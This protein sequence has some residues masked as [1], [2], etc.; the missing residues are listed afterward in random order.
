MKYVVYVLFFLFLS[1]CT[2]YNDVDKTPSIKGDIEDND[3]WYDDMTDEVLFMRVNIP[4]PNDFNCT[5]F[6]DT[7]G[8]LRPCTLADVN[9]DTDANDD[10]EPLLHV[11]MQTDDFLSSPDFMN[12]SFE[13]K[14]KSTR[15]AP[16]KSYRIKLDENISLYRKERTFQ[17]NKHPYD[18]SRVR[19]KLAFDFFREIPHITSL[20]TE[21]VYL[22][23]N[24]SE[25]NS[26]NYGLFTHIEK[27][28][29][30]FLINRG[31]NED[32]NL[33]KAQNF[34]FFLH[35]ELAIDSK[36]KPK[37][38]DLFDTRLEIERGKN[39]TVLDNMLHEVND[40]SNNFDDV[41][42]KYFNRNN[43]ITWMAIN[44]V[45]AN[46]DTVSQNFFLLNPINSDTFYFL[47]WDYDGMG[48]ATEKYAKWELGISTWWE[49]PVHKRFLSIEQNR[50]ELDA[51]VNTLRSVYITPENIQNKLNIYE[52]L[53]S[54]YIARDPDADQLSYD[55]W[56][57]ELNILIPRIDENIANYQS[58]FGHP[59]PFWQEA[60]YE[61]G[62]LTLGWD[63]SVDLEGDIIEYEL[64]VSAS[65]DMNNSF[66]DEIVEEKSALV[67]E[68][69]VYKTEIDLEP[70]KYY[71]R[72][73]SREV[74]N[75]EH[76]QIGF[77]ASVQI[78][79]VYY[80]GVLEF[81]VK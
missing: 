73:I 81:E 4:V 76:Y 72:V 63:R 33:Y 38:P 37:D 10:Y 77:E 16:Q 9:N 20:K 7:N 42:E 39:H 13:Q 12:A 32:D 68:N 19:N 31:W 26:S 18:D 48:R 41:F 49:I 34:A 67:L 65:P 60:L 22:D 56:Q 66:I 50:L 45:L 54:K 15:R 36:G 3:S 11:N 47:P 43:Y 21:F 61:D 24:S 40:Y 35:E 78:D 23:I 80:D 74:N 27:A 6:N 57:N 58:Q 2:S 75:H 8:T 52:Q 70:G 64:K 30:E 71:M 46:K 69:V 79:D 62:V 59:M 17:L 28:G 14:G 53:I 1:G 5:D 51:M 44:I 55:R 25:V 29:K